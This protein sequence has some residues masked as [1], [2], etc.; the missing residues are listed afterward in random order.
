M[1]ERD[2]HGSGARRGPGQRPGAGATAGLG[3]RGHR[4]CRRPSGAR[5]G[6]RFQLS[7]GLGA[8]GLLRR[9]RF[10]PN[11]DP[12]RQPYSS[13]P[14]P[15]VLWRRLRGPVG[16]AHSLFAMLLADT[17][18][19]G[20]VNCGSC[21]YASILVPPERNEGSRPGKLSL[22]AAALCRFYDVELAWRLAARACRALANASRRRWSTSGSVTGRRG[23]RAVAL[24][25][26]R[27]PREAG[28]AVNARETRRWS[29]DSVLAACPR[30]GASAARSARARS[31]FSWRFSAIRCSTNGGQ[32]GDHVVGALLRPPAPPGRGSRR[33]SSCPPPSRSG[34]FGHVSA[35]LV[36]CAS[37]TTAVTTLSK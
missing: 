34:C 35:S 37:A 17:A 8:R 32:A 4:A 15:R 12:I 22:T 33:P 9:R 30:L 18:C 19:Y 14:E 13:G 25:L 16:G 27:P 20:F 21:G 2:E 36:A 10:R 3:E 24:L 11:S 26:P 5:L 28:A 6:A 7:S 29:P 1:E 23:R 31:R